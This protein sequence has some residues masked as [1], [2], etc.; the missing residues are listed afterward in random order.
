MAAHS[1]RSQ[2]SPGRG[3]SVPRGKELK[4]Y[5]EGAARTVRELKD[6]LQRLPR[7]DARGRSDC[8]DAEDLYA[9]KE[10]LEREVIR[11][12][13]TLGMYMAELGEQLRSCE[14]N[15]ARTGAATGRLKRAEARGP[16]TQAQDELWSECTQ[17]R[18]DIHDCSALHQEAKAVARASFTKKFPGRE[19]RRG[20]GFPAAPPRQPGGTGPALPRPRDPGQGGGVVGRGGAVV[21]SSA[22][23]GRAARQRGR[24]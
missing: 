24:R 20:T 3:R 5:L 2:A 22:S 7:V 17:L 11:I 15:L 10:T 1:T 18:Q 12:V 8:P 23:R 14:R 21:E 4:H 16:M 6:A 9:R 19:P 13:E